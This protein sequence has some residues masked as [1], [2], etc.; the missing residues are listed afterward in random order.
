MIYSEF[1]QSPRI[2]CDVLSVKEDPKKEV[3]GEVFSR[4]RGVMVNM[5]NTWVDVTYT[6]KLPN[7]KSLDI[8]K[9]MVNG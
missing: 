2:F 8:E 5:V 6:I 7:G 4:E 9:K 1:I 3:V